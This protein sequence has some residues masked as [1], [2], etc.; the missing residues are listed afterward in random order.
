MRSAIGLP[1]V[2]VCWQIVNATPDRQGFRGSGLAHGAL[3]LVAGQG[4]CLAGDAPVDHALPVIFRPGRE[5]LPDR[6]AVRGSGL[7]HGALGLVAL[8]IIFR[9]E[10]E[11]RAGRS[12]R[13]RFPACPWCAR[14]GGPAHHLQA[15]TGRPAPR[16]CKRIPNPLP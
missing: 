14:L 8:P 1:L 5:S 11:G 9:P 2:S 7:A 15:R 3:G 12:C 6:Q 13:S 4:E 16:G 10:R